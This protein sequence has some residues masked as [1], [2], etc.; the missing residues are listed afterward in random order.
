ME[1]LAKYP[2]PRVGLVWAGR[3]RTG[4]VD[5]AAIDARRS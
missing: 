3:A 4:T 1:Q 5:L 2:H